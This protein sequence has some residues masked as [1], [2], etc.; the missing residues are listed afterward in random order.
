[1]E[2]NK[3]NSTTLTQKR[4]ASAKGLH[5]VCSAVAMLLNILAFVVLAL[6]VTV[7]E[8]MFLVFP[9]A[10]AVLDILFFVKVILSNYR[11]RYAVNG[12]VIHS[13]T[14][15][16][17]AV[18]AYAVIGMLEEKNGIVF[19]TFS[20][21]AMLIVHVVQSIATLATALYATK[22]KKGAAKICGVLFTVVFLACAGIYGRMLLVDGFFGQGGYTD[23]RTVVYRYDAQSKTYTA[24][25]VLDGYGTDV[26][27]PHKFNGSHVSYIDCALFAHE[28]LTSV[29]VAW[30]DND[31]CNEKLGFVGVDHLN[32]LNPELK[33]LAPRGYMD[34]FRR[35]LYALSEQNHYALDLANHV[36][37]ADL[38]GNEVYISFGYDA[39]TLELVGAENII[40]VWIREKGEAFNVR[41]HGKSME[42]VAYSDALNPVHLVWCH[43]KLQEQIF[44]CVVD[45]DGNEIKGIIDESVINATVVFE[46]LY[47]LEIKSDNEAPDKTTIK[48]EHRYMYDGKTKIFDYVITTAGNI[49]SKLDAVK[50]RNG[51]DFVW[52]TG[53]E[54][55]KHVLDLA[56]EL[57]L[58]DAAGKNTLTLYPEWTLK[59]PT[60]N[61]V[62]AGGSAG[63]F[64]AVYG[65]DV[66]L[67][68]AATPPA[69]GISVKYEWFYEDGKEPIAS[70]NAHTLKN[71]YPEGFTGDHVKAGTY[72]LVVTAG[73]D[74]VTQLTS[75][76]EQTIEV[77]FKKKTLDFVWVLPTGA[78]AIYSASSKNGIIEGTA[79]VAADV[80][81]GDDIG[82]KIT[83]NT[84][85][86]LDVKNA[87]N[88]E[89]Q[90][91][92]LPD[93]ALL[94]EIKE[95]KV[96]NSVT[97]SP[98]TLDVAWGKE[99]QFVYNGT[100]QAPTA[101]VTSP[102]DEQ[103]SVNVLGAQKNY[104]KD[105][106]TATAELDGQN[107]VNKNYV[108]STATET[109]NFEILKRKITIENWD[110]NTF[111]YNSK[112]Q[113]PT[114]SAV[115]NLADGEVVGT[116]AGQIV[117][118]VY[119]GQLSNPLE[120]DGYINVNNYRVTASMQADSNYELVNITPREYSITPADLHIKLDDKTMTYDNITY[121]GSGKNF[122]FSF[123]GDAKPQG[124]DDWSKEIFS[125]TY[126]NLATDAVNHGVYDITATISTED[127]IKA[128]NYNIKIVENGELTI[129]KKQLTIFINRE[130]KIYDGTPFVPDQ[131]YF[132]YT[133]LA[134]GN[135]GD[136][137]TDILALNYKIT[138]ENAEVEAI[139]YRPIVYTVSAEFIE[140]EKFDNYEVTLNNGTFLIK[141]RPIKIQPVSAEKVY[142]RTPA[143]N[144]GLSY[145]VLTEEGF[146]DFVHGET[147]GAPIYSSPA[148]NV[149][150][151]GEYE[152]VVKFDEQDTLNNGAMKNYKVTYEKGFYT[153][154]KAPIGITLSPATMEYNGFAPSKELLKGSYSIMYG[155]LD[156]DD[157]GDPVFNRLSSKNAGEYEF[158]ISSFTNKTCADNY[159]IEYDDLKNTL[160]ITPKPI[161]ITV[162]SKEEQYKNAE[163]KYTYNDVE[164]E[165]IVTGVD[166]VAG[167][168]FTFSGDTTKDC[169]TYTVSATIGNGNYEIDTLNN[170]TL[171]ITPRKVEV[172]VNNVLG[173]VYDGKE[174]TDFTVTVDDNV[175]DAAKLRGEIVCSAYKNGA[176]A[177]GINVG[178]YTVSA[179]LNSS[180]DYYKNY[181]ITFNAG[182]LTI[183][184]REIDVNVT[185]GMPK[186]TYNGLPFDVSNFGVALKNSADSGVIDIDIL[187]ADVK[188]T[189]YKGGY[190]VSE[191]VDA[192]TYEIGASLDSTDDYYD[193]YTIKFNPGTLEIEKR[194]VTV[195]VN[196][197]LDY[198]YTGNKFEAC[199]I[200][201]TDDVIDAAKLRGNVAYTFKNASS[202]AISSALN[203]GEY[204]VEAYLNSNDAYY[205]NF[206]LDFAE[207][208]LII[209]P[210]EVEAQVGSSE[211]EYNGVAFDVTKLT[212]TKDESAIL[213]NQNLGSYIYTI[214]KGSADGDIV[215][216]AIDSGEYYVTVACSNA[217]Y[218]VVCTPGKLTITKR[219]ITVTAIATEKTYDGKGNNGPYLNAKITAGELAPRDIKVGELPFGG[220][221]ISGEAVDAVNVGDYEVKVSFVNHDDAA[222][223]YDITY[224]ETTFTIKPREITVTP[225]A[226]TRES[227]GTAG[228][229]FDYNIE[230]VTDADEIE[231]IKGKLGTPKFGGDAVN[232]SKPG[233]Y[234]LTVK[235]AENNNYTVTYNEGKFTIVASEPED[236]IGT[237]ETTA[238]ASTTAAA[239]VLPE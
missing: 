225:T 230:G 202:G 161:N 45:A 149:S 72:K 156:G 206:T 195:K 42:Y 150:N 201:V 208:K 190:N 49:Q 164:V 186:Y 25:D 171:T 209:N 167:L 68:S 153:I 9:L 133:D 136:K 65:S 138:Y 157:L 117:Y 36:Y 89:L 5:L 53:T 33:L 137:I 127:K 220:Y 238:A 176:P 203:A 177:Y 212:V 3:N 239:A 87:G 120:N 147:F 200:S 73:N 233:E 102:Y 175:I 76:A 227:D 216:E 97:I 37:P 61:S 181:D 213:A 182:T 124:N 119:E 224:V 158:S 218:K 131:S 62:T 75:T 63:G 226:D 90:L 135:G 222:V 146:Y 82:Y 159:A 88:Y 118:T 180:D 205:N 78:D 51:F 77:G 145:K 219:S 148:F 96:K 107:A 95:D 7:T 80:I 50:P 165:G 198:V 173:H 83:S 23:Y 105:G 81:N 104:R 54:T 15:L 228:G 52:K 211:S 109:K 19:I 22:S 234:T 134:K 79:F 26:V 154:K 128:G 237:V 91:E 122:T 221:A 55:N 69:E 189:I 46:K 121:V 6:N 187:R 160:T 166:T 168:K 44:K 215:T 67:D 8:I 197:V 178:E 103:V 112:A 170:G 29:E 14:V 151:A 110:S 223:N 113:R 140:A 125:I 184:P 196:D 4:I 99:T 84:S 130:E 59:V 141:Q 199:D 235:F 207:G 114:V 217:N 108:L 142:D 232:A 94:Y 98:Y 58:L 60:I 2:S 185:N 192:G 172:T 179:F 18:L 162:I 85:G 66:L 41:E 17:V 10:F 183:I 34:G 169:G 48:N 106:Y 231:F 11:F 210:I 12:A 40:P 38:K 20:L 214:R 115:N 139:D 152:L 101:S 57:S 92:L 56:E 155:L 47:H 13:V 35:A 236:T 28:E 194:K 21:Y 30:A 64:T 27:I 188:Y 24:I 163:Y 32:F 116:I 111:V 43:N 123:V 39:E 129:N 126:G 93:T 70:A 143:V 229:T 191:A 1:M 204:K 174:Y 144:S 193:N 71:I 74:D 100:D 31:D 132:T 86:T 16:L